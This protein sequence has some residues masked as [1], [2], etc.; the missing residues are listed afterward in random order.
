[1]LD[2]SPHL[3]P[4]RAPVDPFDRPLVRGL[5]SPLRRGMA[6]RTPIPIVQHLRAALFDA[7]A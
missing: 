2:V 7:S 6:E 3:K 4:S 1:L 5:F